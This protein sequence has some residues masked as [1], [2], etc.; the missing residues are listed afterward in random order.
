L[1]D[2]VS[3]KG[4]EG[5]FARLATMIKEVSLCNEEKEIPVLLLI[6]VISQWGAFTNLLWDTDPAPFKFSAGNGISTL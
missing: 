3:P 4:T 6:Q 5:G 2:I 1:H